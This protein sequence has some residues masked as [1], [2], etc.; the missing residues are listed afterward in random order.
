MR[1]QIHGLVLQLRP[2][3]GVGCDDEARELY[4]TP[5]RALAEV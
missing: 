3:G 1:E 5:H 2:Q 4:V